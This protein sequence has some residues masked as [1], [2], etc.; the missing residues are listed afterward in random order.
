ML[1]LISCAKPKNT[2]EVEELLSGQ[3]QYDPIAWNGD[4]ISYTIEDRFDSASTVR[5]F[6]LKTDSGN[7]E[8]TYQNTHLGDSLI[9][10]EPYR[11][12]WIAEYI[13]DNESSGMLYH[14]I[15]DDL[16]IGS[17]HPRLFG[18]A[19]SFKVITD[20][21]ARKIEAIFDANTDNMLVTVESILKL[22]YDTLI[23]S[24][25]EDSRVY[26]RVESPY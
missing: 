26:I 22:T 9:N 18:E 25:Q 10:V 13:F 15:V 4:T 19:S 11:E 16:Q 23:L 21:N 20:G 5:K 14:F 3:W 6:V 24:N 1:G 12:K 7:Y 8:Y 17:M 2:K